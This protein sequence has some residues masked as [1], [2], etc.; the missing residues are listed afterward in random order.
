MNTESSYQLLDCGNFQKYEKIGP[1][2]FVRPSPQA[3]WPSKEPVS[4]W[5][6]KVDAVYERFSEGKGEWKT[7][8]PKLAQ[9]FTIPIHD[10][11]MQLKLTSFGHVGVFFEQLPMW[12]YLQ[13][14]I[15][16]TLKTEPEFKVLNLFAYTGG[17]TVSFLK[18]GADVL[19]LDSSK[20]S[21][22]WAKENAQVAGV[23]DKKVRWMVEDVQKF[24]QKEVRRNSKYHAIILDP[25][26][27]GRGSQNEV[28]K[29][30]E[31]L[32]PLLDN[33]KQLMHENFY[34]MQLSCH[35]QGYTP[36]ALEN[37]LKGY[38]DMNAGSIRSEEMTIPSESGFLLPSGA[39]ALFVSNRIK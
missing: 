12:S 17:A 27:Y 38:V 19:H 37:L 35:S 13:N 9:P 2:Y 36:L 20:T 39:Q 26:S 16:E 29:I 3:V 33:L 34:F 30:E 31:N 15:R 23:A 8:N 10:I 22:S 24:I 28:W 32:I 5:L 21:V 1:F 4:N 14:L 7:K 18:A 6:K 11:Q 25:P